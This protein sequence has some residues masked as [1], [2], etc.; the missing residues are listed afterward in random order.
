MIYTYETF[1]GPSDQLFKIFS[2]YR[3]CPLGAHVDHQHG[4]VTGFA[5]D[6]GVELIFSI[7][8]NS[9]IDIHSLTFQGNVTFDLLQIN[10]QKQNN[11]GDYVRAAV[12]ALKKRLVLRNG[13]KGVIRGN[14]PIGGLSSS[15]AVLVA[16]VM[17]LTKA[18]NIV[19]TPQEIIKITSEA[20]REYIGL[21][22]G[23]LDQACVVLSE[24]DNLLYL[25]TD[26]NEYQLLPQHNDMPPFEIGIIFSGIT[27]SLIATDYNL[28]VS[29]CKTAAWNILAF[30]DQ[31]L[32]TLDKTYLRDVP[33][34]CFNDVK[35][36]LPARFSKRADHFYS[37]CNRVKQ[38]VNAWQKGDLKTFGK[39]V[40]ESCESSINNYECGSKELIELYKMMKETPS[41]YGGRFS[42]AGFKGACIAL[43][44]P[45]YK[46]EIKENITKKYLKKFP[47]LKESFEIHFCK[48]DSAARFIESNN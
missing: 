8:E 47:E 27:R 9:I 33:E 37:E 4:L 3:I 42:G 48:P 23:I 32:H 36:Q 35:H 38:G 7:S 6:K 41:I 24:K 5:F 40:F 43:V 28:R 30:K 34:D 20:E 16:Y 17:A 46:E 1:F 12:Y 19:L 11:W 39:L 44:D 10:G 45:K 15:A 31:T 21:N 13:I 25:D 2:P 18:N 26:N 22:N 29:E 14:L